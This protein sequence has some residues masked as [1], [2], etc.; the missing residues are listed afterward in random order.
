MGY[1]FDRM[2]VGYLFTNDHRLL[3]ILYKNAS[4]V[5]SNVYRVKIESE[6]GAVVSNIQTCALYCVPPFLYAYVSN[7]RTTPDTFI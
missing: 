7:I 6:I 4:S 3:L 5:C 1:I 2:F